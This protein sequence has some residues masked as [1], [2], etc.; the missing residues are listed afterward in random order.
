MARA[1]PRLSVDRARRLALAAQGFA[2]RPPAGKPDVR[3]FRRVLSRVGVVQ[4]DSVNVI[5]R[6]HYLPFFAR[7]GRFDRDALDRWLW[8][9]GR[10]VRVLGARGVADVD[11]PVA[12]R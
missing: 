7:L 10:A 9:L 1:I 12:A 11:R 6:A 8:Q 4:L 5:A 3:H 2:D